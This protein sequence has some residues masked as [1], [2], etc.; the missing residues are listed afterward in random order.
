[1]EQLSELTKTSIPQG[2]YALKSMEE[3]FSDVIEVTDMEA[4]VCAKAK[5]VLK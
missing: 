3:R 2:L 1:M 4:Y 5:E